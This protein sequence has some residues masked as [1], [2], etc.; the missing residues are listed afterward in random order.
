MRQGIGGYSKT[1]RKIYRVE[2]RKKKIKYE[3]KRVCSK[4][5]EL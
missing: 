3:A 2:R 4:I 5:I 1:K